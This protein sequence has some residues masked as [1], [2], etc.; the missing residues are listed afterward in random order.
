MMTVQNN[1]AVIELTVHCRPLPLHDYLVSILGHCYQ[2]SESCSCLSSRLPDGQKL[3]C[4]KEA[5]MSTNR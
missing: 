3:A 2:S 5:L 4:V 1:T